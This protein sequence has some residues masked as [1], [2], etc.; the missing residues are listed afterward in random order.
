MNLDPKQIFLLPEGLNSND[1]LMILYFFHS[2][3]SAETSIKTLKK[4]LRLSKSSVLRIVAKLEGLQILSVRRS[5][6]TREANT[7]CLN[8][9]VLERMVHNPSSLAADVSPASD[10]EP[11]QDPEENSFSMPMFG[12]EIEFR[13]DEQLL[14]LDSQI[15]E[16]SV[17]PELL[18]FL[19]TKSLVFVSTSRLGVR[20]LIPGQGLNFDRFKTLDVHSFA[21]LFSWFRTYTNEQAER[22][23]RLS[24]QARRIEPQRYGA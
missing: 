17:N 18:K 22:E 6:Q 20:K 3:Q 7:Y 4:R 10:I 11:R 2:G 1:L 19:E 13:P 16:S 15:K 24:C 14:L 5:R 21:K 12:E 9:E 8:T 23:A